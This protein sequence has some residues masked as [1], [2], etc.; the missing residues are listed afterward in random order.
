[1][2]LTKNS[3]LWMARS[4]GVAAADLPIPTMS[5]RESAFSVPFSDA[6]L[7]GVV[8]YRVFWTDRVSDAGDRLFNL[9]FDHGPGIEPPPFGMGEMNHSGLKRRDDRPER[10][11]VDDSHER[12]REA[13]RLHAEQ[14]PTADAMDGSSKAEAALAAIREE[15]ES[16]G[17]GSDEPIN[18]GDCVEAVDLLYQR[19]F[20]TGQAASQIHNASLPRTP[21]LSEGSLRRFRILYTEDDIADTAVAPERMIYECDA[22]EV[23]HAI[24]QF[25]DEPTHRDAKILAVDLADGSQAAGP[26]IRNA[27][28][29]YELVHG[30]GAGLPTALIRS[31]DVA[32]CVWPTID[33]VVVDVHAS[34]LEAAEPFERLSVDRKTLSMDAQAHESLK[35]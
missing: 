21:A 15:L 13:W 10:P 17:F 31:E 33:A 5:N 34:G 1:M 9:G 22:E 26:L 3:Y 16:L 24:E 18:G 32:I 35:P 11:F 19:M 8:P 4:L 14:T 30:E 7:V 2:L 28:G 12:S 23:S 29:T 6:T 20:V 27:D 25:H